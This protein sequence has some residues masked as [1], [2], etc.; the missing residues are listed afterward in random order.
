VTS[1]ISPR[2]LDRRV[3]DGLQVTLLW[4]PQTNRLTIEV[5]D[6]VAAQMFEF[7]VPPQCADDAFRHPY[8]YAPTAIVL[9]AAERR[10]VSVSPRGLA[11]C[12]T[13]RKRTLTP[14]TGADV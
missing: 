1:D 6:D 14:A 10:T 7:D 13:Q 8:A 12:A 2:E 4:N 11:P 9:R 5:Y 3:S